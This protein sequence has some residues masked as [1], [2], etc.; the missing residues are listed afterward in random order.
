MVRKE[1][2]V[3]EKVSGLVMATVKRRLLECNNIRSEAAYAIAQN[4]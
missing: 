1:V 4:L 3:A 2:T